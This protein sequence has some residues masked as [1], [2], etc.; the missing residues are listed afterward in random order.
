MRCVCGECGKC[1][2]EDA[3]DFSEIPEPSELIDFQVVA[4]EVVGMVLDIAVSLISRL[5]PCGVN[6]DR[7]GQ[8]SGTRQ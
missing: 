3:D 6:G 4:R 2:W 8:T 5:P 1:L 7:R